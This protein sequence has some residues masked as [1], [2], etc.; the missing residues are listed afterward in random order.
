MEFFEEDT[1]AG[2]ERRKLT[3]Y[4][5]NVDATLRLL[6]GGIQP[7]YEMPEDMEGLETSLGLRRGWVINIS[8]SGFGFKV[9][10]PPERLYD[11]LKRQSDYRHA[12]VRCKL[13]DSTRTVTLCGEVAW[14]DVLLGPVTMFH[15]GVQLGDLNAEAYSEYKQCLLKLE[16]EQVG[17]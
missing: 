8:R 5:V 15:L 16:D 12:S 9:L 11:E 10:N 1:Q 6:P 3:R 17:V 4:I 7:A 14:F 2:I 13:P